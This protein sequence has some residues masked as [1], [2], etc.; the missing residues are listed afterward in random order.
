MAQDQYG[1]LWFGTI[2]GLLRYDGY[3]LKSYKHDTGNPN[4]L[5]ETTSN[6]FTEI[7]PAFFGSPL[8]MEGSIRL[9]PAQDTFTH[10]RH[11]PGNQQSLSSNDVRCVYQESGGALWIG[12]LAGL[13][14][15]DLATGSFIHYRHDA[16]DEGSLSSDTVLT[17]FEDRQG[18]LWV[19]TTRRSEQAGAE[20]GPVFALPARP[21]QSPQPGSRL[22]EFHP[23]GP[24]RCSMGGLS[25][26]KAVERP[27]REDR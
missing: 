14:R 5:T 2:D 15:L 23:G 20:H 6:L 22:R 17:V 7:G 25:E 1:F 9:D 26:C 12:T 24:V 21:G 3:N 13:D 10:Y 16:E 27:G 19:G 11:D 18:N 4:S 8:P